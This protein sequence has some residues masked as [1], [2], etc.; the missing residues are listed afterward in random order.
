MLV[1][2]IIAESFTRIIRSTAVQYHHPI[3]AV[4]FLQ[5]NYGSWLGRE[6]NFLQGEGGQAPL[7]PPISLAAALGLVE[8]IGVNFLQIV[9]GAHGPFLPLPFLL[10]P[11]PS[12]P[13][14]SPPSL[15]LSLEVGPPNP[16]IGGLGE[17]CKLPQRGLGRSPSRNRI[18]CT[19]ALK[20]VI[21][22][23]QF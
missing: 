15:S 20:S 13:L 23:Q 9:G 21:W 12:P 19:L 16:A 17:R 10:L 8:R 2:T 14:T 11:F 1:T 3:V 6:Q 5:Y 18:W 7:T 4:R 22:W